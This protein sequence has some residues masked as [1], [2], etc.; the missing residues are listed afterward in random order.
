MCLVNNATVTRT[1]NLK[2]ETLQTTVD[3]WLILGN[4]AMHK[5]KYFFFFFF[6]HEKLNAMTVGKKRDGVRKYWRAAT[7]GSKVQV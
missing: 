5:I 2:P 4:K 7:S 6:L 3:K 1:K